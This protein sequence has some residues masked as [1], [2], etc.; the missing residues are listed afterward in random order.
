MELFKSEYE[1]F[2]DNIKKMCPK[3]LVQIENTLVIDEIGYEMGFFKEPLYTFSLK[4]ENKD[5][6][7]LLNQINNLHAQALNDGVFDD[8]MYSNFDELSDFLNILKCILLN[9]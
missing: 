7:K 8:E 6:N 1:N 4:L 5:Y 2:I 3:Y 9:G